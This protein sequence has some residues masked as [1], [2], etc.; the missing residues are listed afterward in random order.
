MLF[1]QE[2]PE[3]TRPEHAVDD[4]DT[5]VVLATVISHKMLLFQ[6]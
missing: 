6:Q 4:M 3:V 1:V 2:N 5:A